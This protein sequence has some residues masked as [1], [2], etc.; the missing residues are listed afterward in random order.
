MCLAFGISQFLV[1]VALIFDID[2][3][4]VVV[5]LYFYLYLIYAIFIF[6]SIQ[7]LLRLG[8]NVFVNSIL[9]NLI[10]FWELDLF[11]SYACLSSQSAML[12][13]DV[14]LFD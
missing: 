11:L 5:S 2:C 6:H 4:I 14:Y 8:V 1:D 10:R 9:H 13:S 7:W 12:E 3:V